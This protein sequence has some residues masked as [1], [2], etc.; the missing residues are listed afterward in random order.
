[1]AEIHEDYYLVEE[2]LDYKFKN[3][4]L[5]YQAFTRSSYAKQFG[6]QDNE[7]L[8]FIGDEV[9]DYLVTKILAKTFGFLQ[10]ESNFFDPNKDFNDFSIKVRKN[11]KNYTEI[12]KD[13]VCNENLAR[14]MNKYGFH[15]YL[16]LGDSDKK[17]NVV[18]QMKV[19]ADLFEA[20]VG[21]M[22]ID[23]NWKLDEI[24]ESVAN[25]LDLDNFFE[26]LDDCSDEYPAKCKLSTAINS[27]KELFEHGYI[28]QP[29]Y[30]MP[31]EQVFQDGRYWWACTCKVQCFHICESRLATS[32]KFAK[33]CAAYLA[34]CKYYG[35]AP[36]E[37]EK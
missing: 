10:E 23:V 30:E 5:L 33:Q 21:A 20:I 24:E 6:G 11:E 17:N 28:S 32:K 13:I 9:L 34:L 35:V 4:D 14:L 37:L 25:F 31:L 27:L 22:A 29:I 36:V 3:R 19:K 8:E 7:V 18:N 16:Y 15:K 26:K 1:M 2:V 12:K